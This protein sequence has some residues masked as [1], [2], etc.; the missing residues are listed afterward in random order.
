MDAE[1]VED[2]AELGF[3]GEVAPAHFRR[4][5]LGTKSLA[6][7]D[8]DLAFS[9]GEAGEERD[10]PGGELAV[11]IAAGAA[12][13]ELDVEDG[14]QPGALEQRAHGDFGVHPELVLT[15]EQR[16][17]R[18]IAET[19]RGFFPL[20]AEVGAGLSQRG[21]DAEGAAGIE[22]GRAALAVIP[23]GAGLGGLA[24]A[25]EGAQFPVEQEHADRQVLEQAGEVAAEK[26]IFLV[27]EGAAE[28]G[29]QVR[30]ERFGEL[31]FAQREI[32]LSD[33]AVKIEQTEEMVSAPD[34]DAEQRLGA[35]PARRA[36]GGG[37][38]R[39]DVGQTEGGDARVLDHPGA[40][41]L[42]A[43]DGA[44]RGRPVEAVGFLRHAVGIV[45]DLEREGV[46]RQR[47]RSDEADGLPQFTF[48][49][50][51]ME[52]QQGGPEGGGGRIGGNQRRGARG[53]REGNHTTSK[54]FAE[55]NATRG[56]P[57]Y[58]FRSMVA[59]RGCG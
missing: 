43:L 9:G 5:F 22:R 42:L 48:G 56:V 26:K 2:G 38:F 39:V 45:S 20:G 6:D 40:V 41:R 25:P 12:V 19:I 37:R 59:G 4:D 10:G 14:A 13:V 44:R 31:D 24:V 16:A 32:G 57:K 11:A 21:R 33:G 46:A 27:R 1:L 29:L 49:E 53:M 50:R 35:R 47:G 30:L 58:L 55:S 54:A 36:G 23:D 28:R 8:G 15:E 18:M 52:T 3:D 34:R 51:G 7:A 17:R